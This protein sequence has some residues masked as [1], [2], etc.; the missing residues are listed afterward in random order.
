M[1][2]AIVVYSP[3]ELDSQLT[4]WTAP[5]G[6]ALYFVVDTF[7]LLALNFPEQPSAKNWT[8]WT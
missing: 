6:S 8:S 7:C 2:L 4:L 3:D 1:S 5:V